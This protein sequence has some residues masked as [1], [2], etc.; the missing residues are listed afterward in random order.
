MARASRLTVYLSQD[1]QFRHR[2]IYTE[3]VHRAHEAGLAGATVLRGIEG[4]GASGRIHTA[5][6]LSL[7]EHLPAVVVIL[8]HPERIR[9][10]LPQLRELVVEGL[11]TI[12]DVEILSTGGAGTTLSK[13]E[14]EAHDRWPEED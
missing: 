12:D 11:V 13:S 4:N 5:R 2:P 6:L 10:F 9:E 14:P 1:D 3:I 7:A 8:D